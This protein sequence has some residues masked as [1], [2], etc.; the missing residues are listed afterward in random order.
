MPLLADPEKKATEITC[1]GEMSFDAK[2]GIVV[3][4]KNV[5]IVDEQFTLTADK[6][7][8]WVKKPL[9]KSAEDQKKD[10]PA[11]GLERVVAEGSV[12][13]SQERPDEKTGKPVLYSG[14]AAKAE[15]DTATGDLTLSGWPQIS[16][17]QN[18]QKASQENTVMMMNRE[19]RLRTK[20]PSMTVIQTDA[21]QPHLKKKP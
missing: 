15:Y 17:G 3:F 11:A 14:T 18:V 4:E 16:Q 21:Q 12:I 6:L 2:E 19:G 9:K 10:D 5:K 8:A 13:I 1:D 7:T 20:G